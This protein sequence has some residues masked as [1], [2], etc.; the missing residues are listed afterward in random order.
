MIE[1]LLFI[2]SSPTLIIALFACILFGSISFV[3]AIELC[4]VKG[5]GVSSLKYLLTLISI[6]SLSNFFMII[7][8][9]SE[10]VKHSLLFNSVQF[11]V[12]IL[13]CWILFYEARW[14]FTRPIV[15]RF[16]FKIK[17]S[18]MKNIKQ[19]ITKKI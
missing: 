7:L 9:P 8:S 4:S 5:L 19:L 2:I 18:F 1:S 15:I 16:G 10:F 6:E 17:S 13:L 3:S 14:L 12:G 11:G